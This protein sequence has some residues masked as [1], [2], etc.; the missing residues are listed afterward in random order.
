M[1]LTGVREVQ[2]S[3]FVTFFLSF[4]VRLIAP[5][6]PQHTLPCNVLS[7]TYSETNEAAEE[8]KNPCFSV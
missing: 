6:T 8:E 3:R 1:S 2:G 5:R 7:S 4:L